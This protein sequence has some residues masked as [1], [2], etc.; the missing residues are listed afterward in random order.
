[1]PL[2]LRPRAFYG[3]FDRF[4]SHKGAA[5]HIDR[6]ARA[7]FAHLGGGGL[8][9][10]LGGDGLPPYQ[11]EGNVEIVRF[12]RSVPNFLARVLGYRG[13]LAALL[14]QADADRSLEICHFRDP[15]TGI[16]VLERPH[17]YA[18]VYE[19]NGLPSIELPLSYP[20]VDDQTL[21][22]VRADERR[23]WT[24]ADLVVV[25]AATL[26]DTL[27]RLGCAPEKIAVV[28]NG[29][30]LREG[31][32]PGRP[33]D[34]PA[35]YLLYFGALQPWQG[36]G[37][38]LRAF[39]RLADFPDLHL[40]VCASQAG[41]Q[42]EAE[43]RLANRLGIAERT[44]WRVALDEA[45]L[46]PW[47]AHALASLAPLSECARNVLQGCA[48]LKILESMAAGVPVVA[49]DLASTREIITD[50]VDGRL[51]PAD[52]PAELARAV[53]LL[54]E[55]PGE[56]ARLAEEGRR[57]IARRFRW[58]GALAQLTQLYDGV[59]GKRRVAC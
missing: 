10:V 21:G 54:L 27:V 57:T 15:W 59:L 32:P 34:A 12:S 52:R 13:R 49:S 55:Y 26:R 42:L 36:V 43:Q 53:R 46:A 17:G 11:R 58:D 33:A 20:A 18:C 28:P 56:R 35:S 39:A 37:T 44:L 41:R 50:G 38:L 23:C 5:V 30:D 22:K 3:A 45:E 25:P 1:M 4:P 6:F 19:V 40:V 8:L 7:L 16:P 51:V 31:P 24:E 29:A 14:D 48:P 47:R 9:Y 2:S